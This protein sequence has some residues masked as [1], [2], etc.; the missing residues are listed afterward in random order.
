MAVKKK[1]LKKNFKKDLRTKAVKIKCCYCDIKNDCKIKARKEKSENK[2]C[3]T[4]CLLTPN[5]PKKQK[6]KIKR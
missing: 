1:K 4:Y 2:G 5:I 6:K 3:T